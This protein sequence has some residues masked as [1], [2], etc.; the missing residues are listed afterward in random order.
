MR[1]K[2]L[3]IKNFYPVSP[4]FDTIDTLWNALKPFKEWLW[5]NKFLV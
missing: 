2:E 1:K 5:R 4:R 3:T